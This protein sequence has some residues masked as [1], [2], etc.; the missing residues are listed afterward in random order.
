MVAV[1]WL[2]QVFGAAWDVLRLSTPAAL[3]SS[4]AWSVAIGV[5]LFAGLSVVLGQIAVFRINRVHGWQLALGVAIGSTAD[6][7]LRVLI[8]VLLG[9]LSWSVDRD[10]TGA[11]SLVLGYLF[12]TAPQLLGF[13]AAI[14]Y[15]G[16]AISR[17]LEG[18]SMLALAVMVT[19]ATANP[20]LA[21]LV[22]AVAWGLGQLL[23]RLLAHPL[24]TAASWLWTQISGKPTITTTNDILAGAPLIPLEKTQ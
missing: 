11:T 13:L 2:A 21:L 18:W 10:G 8:G 6:A 9:L 23:S 7:A 15:I 19:T 4:D 22:S 24:S 16:L 12:A 14:P 5:A 20:W 17:L 1:N 3:G